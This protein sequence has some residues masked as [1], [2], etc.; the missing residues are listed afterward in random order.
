MAARA[1]RSIGYRALHGAGCEKG[2]ECQG[3]PAEHSPGAGKDSSMPRP[4]IF[5]PIRSLCRSGRPSSV[6]LSRAYSVFIFFLL[7]PIAFCVE[8]P[9]ADFR[10]AL[11]YHL[12]IVP[13]QAVVEVGSLA[14]LDLEIDGAE[15]NLDLSKIS[16]RLIAEPSL[17]AI[18]EAGFAE[19]G[20]FIP[21]AFVVK[22]Q[23]VYGAVTSVTYS[24]ASITVKG[25]TRSEGLLA[26]LFVIAAQPGDVQLR[27]EDLEAKDSHWAVLPPP[28]T[29]PAGFQIVSASPSPTETSTPSETPT[30]TSTEFPSDTPTPTVT[31]TPEDSPTPTETPTVTPTPSPL[32]SILLSPPSGVFT[33]GEITLV[34]VVIAG[35]P[36]GLSLSEVQFEFEIDG[37]GR[38]VLLIDPDGCV[39]GDFIANATLAIADLAP[40]ASRATSAR[41]I[42]S[43]T[44][45]GGESLLS[46]KLMD[47][48]L[49]GNQIGLADLRILSASPVR[50][51]SG[52]LLWPPA[53]PALQSPVRVDWPVT[54]L[55]IE[56]YFEQ[57]ENLRGDPLG[58]KREFRTK[59]SLDGW[60]EAPSSG[61]E[62][63]KR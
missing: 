52:A 14:T 33:Q 1:E 60:Q 30:P 32:F 13:G 12:K 56:S 36:A 35:A 47:I 2:I 44:Q 25:S 26:R 18:P 28:E 50:D 51:A 15:S 57:G 38:E 63:A 27:L 31:E 21:D 6:R 61:N 37:R 9:G 54:G 29:V 17:I 5:Q 43:G 55:P 49:S 39:P 22:S 48:A 11:G 19:P 45:P 7:L 23:P 4:R 59:F 10:I 8:S 3:D 16:F 53:L 24:V 42:L 20:P 40:S 46:N 62:K 58:W 34:P 41:F